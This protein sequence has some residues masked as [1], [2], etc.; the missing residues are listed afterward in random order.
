MLSIP[1]NSSEPAPR[2][3]GTTIGPAVR[4]VAGV[5]RAWR[6]IPFEVKVAVLVLALCLPYAVTYSHLVHISLLD[7]MRSDIQ[8]PRYAQPAHVHNT[9]EWFLL[10]TPAVGGWIGATGSTLYL[11]RW[12]GCP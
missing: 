4:R 11:A 5:Q 8:L 12:R 1:A 2:P 9:V 3:P 7:H 6:Q 10:I